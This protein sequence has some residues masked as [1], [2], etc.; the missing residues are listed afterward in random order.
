MQTLSTA[1][2]A[3]CTVAAIALAALI[4]LSSLGTGP[5]PASGEPSSPHVAAG[6]VTDTCAA[7]HRSHTGQNDRLV[8][9]V[10]QTTLCFTCHDG[11]GSM[12]DVAAEYSDPGIPA[13]DAATS[14]F[15]SH[16]SAN[17]AS[18]TSAR[19]DEFAGVLNRHAECSDCHN[20]HS[21]TSA[22]AA[23]TGTGWL[24]SG[25]LLGTAGV[26]ATS[27]PAWRDPLIYE[28]ELCL[29]CHSDYTQLLSYTSQSE[30]KT[31]KA[32]EFDPSN[33]SYHPVRAPGTNTTAAMD[34]SLAGGSLW[35]FTSASTIRCVNCHANGSLAGGSPTWYGKLAPHTSQNRG[36]LLANYR[37]R[38]L[39]PDV[40]P[41]SA[42]DFALCY[43]CH[44]AAAFETQATEPRADTN[45]P[46][47]GL[48]VT[49]LPGGGGGSLDI[50]DPGAGQGS[51]ICAECH[52]EL[53][54]TRFAPYSSNQAYSRG[55]NFAPN[56]QPIPGAPEPE[57]S[58]PAGRT[59]ALVCHGQ[60]HEDEPY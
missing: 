42:A 59:C 56:V 40:E 12:Y 41:Y 55:V 54:S 28:Y 38:D 5:S 43:L 24:A 51:A 39:K 4:G 58:G 52:F 46:L 53:H 10:P 21:L 49:G 34:N 35:Q 15:Y 57:W 22:D 16:T 47:H 1:I 36:L 13:N 3:T 48:H 60:N 2:R 33:A 7:C 14:S 31:D 29:K 20:P 23:A 8:E 44:S 50:D 11:T 25:S 27:P 30:K 17:P 37:D 9:S 32:T 6:V 19:V 45:F 18:H 26:A